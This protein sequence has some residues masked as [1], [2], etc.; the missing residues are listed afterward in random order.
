MASEGATCIN[1][2]ALVYIS[3]S[4]CMLISWQASV[5]FQRVLTDLCLSEHLR[6]EERVEREI[7]R[8]HDIK[9][10]A[11]GSVYEHYSVCISII[12]LYHIV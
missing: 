5:G 11:R 10:Q 8:L 2:S 6:G 1:S 12:Y 3:A 9:L 4:G 7:R